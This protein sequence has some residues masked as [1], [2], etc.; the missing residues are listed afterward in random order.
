MGRLASSKLSKANSEHGIN[1]P[2]AIYLRFAAE[3]PV[4]P[5]QTS[6]GR[7]VEVQVRHVSLM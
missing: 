1:E 7:N 2:S 5:P 3:S 6:I 4:R